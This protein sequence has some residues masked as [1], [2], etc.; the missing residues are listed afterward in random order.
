MVCDLRRCTRA[1]VRHRRVNLRSCRT[2]SGRPADSTLPGTGTSSA[3]GRLARES[4]RPRPLLVGLLEGLLLG[5]RRWGRGRTSWHARG[6]LR[7]LVLRSRRLLIL[8]GGLRRQA[9]ALT[10]LAGHYPAKKIVP[11]ANGGR[12]RA[13]RRTGMLRGPG[14]TW[15]RSSASSLLKLATEDNDLLIVPVIEQLVRR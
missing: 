3:R 15:L 4:I 10:P 2:A 11:H 14:N 6:G 9:S 7:H 1:A 13:G 5:R 8:G 12:W